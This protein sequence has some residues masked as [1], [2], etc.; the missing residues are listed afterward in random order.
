M[1]QGDNP[2]EIS[3][4]L[5][6]ATAKAMRDLD[7]AMRLNRAQATIR[8]IAGKA[9]V[10]TGISDLIAEK[11][12][13]LKVTERVLNDFYLERRMSHSL[14]KHDTADV[15]ARLSGIV[16]RMETVTNDM[17]SDVVRVP[18]LSDADLSHLQTRLAE[19]HRRQREVS[20]ELARANIG[21]TIVLPDEVVTVLRKHQIV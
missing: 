20:R 13:Y 18:K 8:A 16:K 7:D 12:T 15:A 2:D 19:I 10:E 5:R 21:K 17:V 1:T 3:E 9:N 14:S 4:A 6:A 11:E